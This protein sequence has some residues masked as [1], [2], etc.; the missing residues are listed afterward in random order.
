MN[1]FK[2]LGNVV[3]LQRNKQPK[4]NQEE[5]NQRIIQE[6]ESQGKPV[7]PPHIVK[8]KV[9]NFYKEKFAVEWLVETGTFMGEMVEAQKNR[10]SR[11]ISIELQG[12][13]YEEAVKKFKSDKHVKLYQGDSG[14]VLEKIINEITGPAIFWL[15]GHYSAGVTAKGNLNTPIIKEL[16]CVLGT[17]FDH[18]V[19]IDDARLFVGK[20]DYP[21]L[22]ELKAF[23]QKNAPSYSMEV[24]DD[25][26]RL[27]K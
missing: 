24:Q 10:F 7:P 19:L 17:K 22:E 8:Q 12:R 5:E 9:I 6:W 23:I 21:T 2:K 3:T 14:E 18:V 13:L 27:H 20:E 11:I 26:I 16:Q 1:I 4:H 25:I 15:D